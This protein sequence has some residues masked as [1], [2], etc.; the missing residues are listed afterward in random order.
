MIKKEKVVAIVPSYN[1]EPRISKVIEPLSKSKIIDEIIVIDDG[2]TDNTKRIVKKFKNIRYIK[3]NT[4]NGKA[5]SMDNGIKLSSAPIIFFC[6][7]DLRGLTPKI[8]KAIVKPVAEKKVDMF[9][10]MRNNKMQKM[11]KPFGI[12]SGER[13]IR[14]EIW[15]KL[16]EYYKKGFRIECGL[17]KFVEKFGNGYGYKIFPYYQTLKENKYGLFKGTIF[18]WIMNFD[19][20]IAWMRF[21]MIDRFRK[22][23]F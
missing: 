1:E 5:N 8:I 3:N 14:R 9:I 22:F 12:N 11:Y 6:D 23:S 13:A 19:V 16:P 17:N 15:E 4:N 2:S 21:Q 18:R 7:A 10:G 20:L